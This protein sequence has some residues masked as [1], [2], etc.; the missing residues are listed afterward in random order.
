MARDSMWDSVPVIS[1]MS[2]MPVTG[3][4]TTAAKYPAMPRIT[5]FS[6]CTSSPTAAA[7]P[8]TRLPATAPSTSSGTPA[9]KLRM[10]YANRTASRPNSPHRAV[11]P[12]RPAISPWPPPRTAGQTK[13][14]I[15]AS[16]KGMAVLI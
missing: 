6:R 8:P 2:S 5:K 11:C 3:A 12:V 16:I 15:P 13:P 4:R 7:V 9:L 1:Q 14:R 10:E